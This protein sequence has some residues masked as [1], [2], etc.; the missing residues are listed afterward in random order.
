MNAREVRRLAE[1]SIWELELNRRGYVHLAGVDEAGRGPL[2]GPVVAAVVILP[3][4]LL[5]EGVRDSKQ[6]NPIERESLSE[7]IKSQAIDYAIGIIRSEIIDQVNILQATYLAVR[8][9]LLTLKEPPDFLL[10]DA[11]NLPD[12][13]IDQLAIIKGDSLC[14][15]IAAASILAKV[16]RDHLMRE[17]HRV[18]PHYNFLAHKGYGTAEHLRLLREHGPCPIHRTSFKGVREVDA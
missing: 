15:S 9:A 4:G 12:V 7:V 16:T 3:I 17:Y 10:T 1:M 18:Y 13:A 6:L 14:H 5:I 2:A 11:L 8:Q